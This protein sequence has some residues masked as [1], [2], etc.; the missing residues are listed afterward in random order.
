MPTQVSAGNSGNIC[1][2]DNIFD[3]HLGDLKYKKSNGNLWYLVR[4]SKI[5]MMW[6]I[7]CNTPGGNIKCLHLIFFLA[8]TEHIFTEYNSYFGY[9]F[10]HAGNL[11]VSAKFWYACP[12][13]AGNLR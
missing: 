8:T 10:G 2:I 4:F 3:E 6:Q 1:H 11:Q 7:F 5:L 9:L 12:N 13:L